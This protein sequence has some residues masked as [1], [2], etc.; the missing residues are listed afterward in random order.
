KKKAREELE[1]SG[2][3]ET[4]RG[5]E[6]LFPPHKNIFSIEESSTLQRVY[7]P[8]LQVDLQYLSPFDNSFLSF[9][10]NNNVGGLQRQYGYLV[11]ILGSQG[12]NI[13]STYYRP[14]WSL[15]M[16]IIVLKMTTTYS[17]ISDIN[18]GN[19]TANS[20]GIAN[21]KCRQ[22]VGETSISHPN[23]IVTTAHANENEGSESNEIDCDAY[24]DFSNMDD[25]FQ[26]IE[27]PSY[28]LPNENDSEFD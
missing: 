8:Q 27:S 28:K 19:A 16:G 11:G 20:L 4:Q 2:D 5:P 17:V 21:A 3:Q 15:T 9:I 7:H 26:K 23:N 25:L 14:V 13:G 1:E 22:Y 10:K 18:N 24:I 6:F 12:S